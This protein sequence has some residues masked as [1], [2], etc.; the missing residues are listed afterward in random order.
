MTVALN[1]RIP[2]EMSDRITRFQKDMGARS[3]TAALVHLIE[4]GLT[5]Y[6]Y[7]KMVQ[8]EVEGGLVTLE[9]PPAEPSVEASPVEEPPAPEKKEG[10]KP[11]SGKKGR[12][13]KLTEVM[14]EA[15]LAPAKE[16]AKRLCEHAEARIAELRARYSC[17]D[18]VAQV[19]QKL[20]PSA[21][22]DLF[23]TVEHWETLGTYPVD[24]VEE[25]INWWI[26]DESPAVKGLSEVV[27]RAVKLRETANAPSPST[28]AG[29]LSI[30]TSI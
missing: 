27:F 4:G 6:G 20:E 26:M 11:Q 1:I 2:D 19:I 22:K 30:S 13:K 24:L 10:K 28:S 29:P 9:D 15:E 12:P 21:T 7:S 8:G 17:P 5:G 16:E 25:A 3:K 14:S 23:L 18:L